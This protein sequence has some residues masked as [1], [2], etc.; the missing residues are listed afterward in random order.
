MLSDF[1]SPS[2]FVV[3][4]VYSARDKFNQ[5]SPEEFRWKIFAVK[6]FQWRIFVMISSDQCRTVK[7]DL[8][9]MFNVVGTFVLRAEDF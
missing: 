3:V 7:G 9:N 4:V 2:R 5:H 8:R 6:D 1:L